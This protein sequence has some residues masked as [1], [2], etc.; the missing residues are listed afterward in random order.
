[1]INKYSRHIS[2]RYRI[3]KGGSYNNI[4]LL[5]VAIVIIVFIVTKIF[6]KGDKTIKI[7][8]KNYLYRTS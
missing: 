1:M 6:K 4:G 8:E 5:F 2:K 3:I 7:T